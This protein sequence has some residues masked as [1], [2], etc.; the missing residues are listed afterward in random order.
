MYKVYINQTPLYLC[1]SNEITGRGPADENNLVA[2]YPG[3]PKFLFNYVDMLEKSQRLDSITVFDDDLERLWNDFLGNYR[4]IEAAGGLVLNPEGQ[5]LFIF[6]RHY[7]DLPK[8]KI[9]KG[10]SVKAAAVREIEEETGI[11]QPEIRSELPVTYHTYREKNSKRVLKC[12]HW[13]V[14]T[15]NQH[16]LTPQQEEDIEVAMWKPIDEMALAT[17][18]YGSIKDVLEAYLKSKA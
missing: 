5:A 8:G 14:M 4:W 16:E 2:R 3:K 9:D 18:M 1:A 13:F 6:R 11:V 17:P 7:W 12:T 15:T 10:E